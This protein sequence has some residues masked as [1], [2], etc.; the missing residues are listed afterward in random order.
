MKEIHPKYKCVRAGA[1]TSRKLNK[2]YCFKVNGEVK[3]VCKTFFKNTLDISDRPIRTS[4]EKQSGAVG[5][6]LKDDRRGKHKN[7]KELD[8]ELMK[9]I[10]AHIDSIPRIESHYLR[11][12]TTRQYICGS[13][14]TADIHRDYKQVCLQYNQ[15]A[16][17]YACF[18][19]VFNE[20]YNISLFVPKK[21]K[22]IEC[23][24]FDNST[25]ADREPL[26]EEHDTHLKEK[27]LAR[28][29]KLRDKTETKTVVAV[30]DLQ[31]VMQI[32]KGVYYYVSKLNAFDFTVINPKTHEAICYGWD[33]SE[34]ARGANELGS[35]FYKNLEKV[36]AECP[37]A[38]VI[39]WSDNCVG[40]QKNQFMVTLYVHAL[41]SLKLNCITH[42][43]SIKGHTQNEADS[44]HSLIERNVQKLVK[45]NRRFYNCHQGCE[46]N[47]A[48]Y[49]RGTPFP[50]RFLRLEKV[51]QGFGA[52]QHGRGKIGLCASTEANSGVPQQNIPQI[53][54]HRD[55]L[56]GGGFN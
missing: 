52:I 36:A 51:E 24:I 50:R 55:K 10:R 17:T 43:F 9:G 5:G 33:E 40:Q 44:V 12:N 16:V 20:K 48:T 18:N 7:H 30:Y 11:A 37:G 47:R 31:A 6:V 27:E 49:S 13:K 26:Q 14:T 38:D 41:R 28:A 45:A 8:A 34:A 29:E 23:T 4:I 46:E 2:S 39:F 3:T 22:C 21:D 42:R 19:K 15:V 32:P 1:P 56:Q 35:C 54:L 53:L 25:E